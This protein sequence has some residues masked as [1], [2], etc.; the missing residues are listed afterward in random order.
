MMIASHLVDPAEI[1]VSWEQIGGL[2]SVIQEIKE[3]VI[4]PIKRKDLFTDSHLTSPPKGVLLHGP[5]G[6]GNY[7]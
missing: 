3:T 7:Y 2:Q 4:L 6:C 1:T 5:P